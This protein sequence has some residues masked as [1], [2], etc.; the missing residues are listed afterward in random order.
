M[1]IDTNK[2]C[3]QQALAD[4]CGISQPMVSGLL[5][6][7]VLTAN[8]I[9]AVWLLEYAAHLRKQAENR[10]GGSDLA[11]ERAGLAKEQR[12]RAEMINLRERAEYAPISEL[13]NGYVAVLKEVSSELLKIPNLIKGSSENFSLAD[14][15]LVQKIITATVID[16]Q[17]SKIDWFGLTREEKENE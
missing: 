2:Q 9:F 12:I 6:R 17:S 15:E 8:A 11:N 13:S 5:N 10:P 16:M 4:F 3:T 7:G 1:E 14:I